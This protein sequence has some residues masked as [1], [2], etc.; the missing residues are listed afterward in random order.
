MSPSS[1]DPT[2]PSAVLANIKARGYRN[3]ATGT[4]CARLSDAAAVDIP[5]LVDAVE[6]ALKV[7]DRLTADAL[8]LRSTRAQVREEC[9]RVFRETIEAALTGTQLEEGG[10]HG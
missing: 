8:R 1:A 4:Q 10:E 6:A 9:A 2:T 3:G 5:L 7:T